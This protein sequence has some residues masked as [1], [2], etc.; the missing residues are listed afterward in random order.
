[1]GL[2][3]CAECGRL[4]DADALQCDQ[5]GTAVAKATPTASASKRP[6]RAAPVVAT[7]PVAQARSTRSGQMVVARETVDVVDPQTHKIVH[8]IAGR[9]RVGDGCWIHK[10]IPSAFQYIAA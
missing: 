2:T 1:M 3:A 10:L 6:R 7:R 5:C 8:V 9:T 4:N